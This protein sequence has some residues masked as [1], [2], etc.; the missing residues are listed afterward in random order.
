[1]FAEVLGDQGAE[2]ARRPSDEPCLHGNG[3]LG[4]K[5]RGGH[6]GRTAARSVMEGSREHF[7][8]L[9]QVAGR[10]REESKLAADRVGRR[11]PS[12]YPAR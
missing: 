11:R 3:P 12:R 2:A 1:M 10:V 8:Q 6:R 5:C 4:W 9:D 7:G